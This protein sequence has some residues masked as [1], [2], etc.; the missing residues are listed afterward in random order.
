M[1]FRN[2]T[3]DVLD[4]NG[5]NLRDGRLFLSEN[6]DRP[7]VTVAG[8]EFTHQLRADA[9]DL[10]AQLEAEV[11]R[12]GDLTG[13]ADK[14]RRQGE[15]DPDRV[16]PE[17]LTADAV[18]DAL[19][20]RAFL[21][22]LAERNPGVFR[23]VAEA[24][25]RFLDGLLAKLGRVRDLGSNRYLRDVQAF[26]DVLDDVLAKYAPRHVAKDEPSWI[27]GAGAAE[28]P[29]STPALSE[30]SETTL[31]RNGGEA[32]ASEAPAQTDTPEFRR[33]FGD[34]KVVNADGT[35]RTVYHGTG[36]EFWAFKGDRLGDST[37][38]M[39]APLG[40]FFAEDRAKAERY[41]E[42]AADYVPADQRVIDAH[43][44]IRNPKRM[45]L[46]ELMAVDN[47]DEA[48]AL[49]SKLEREGHDGIHVPEI[50]QWV[51]FEPTQIKSASE[52]RGSFDPENPDIRYSRG[53]PGERDLAGDTRAKLARMQA[54]EARRQVNAGRAAVLSKLAADGYPLGAPGWQQNTGRWEGVRGTLHDARVALQE[55]SSLWLLLADLSQ[56]SCRHG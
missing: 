26:R 6:A 51:A 14:L 33:W 20:D 28:R 30:G 38:H 27:P 54:S 17:E 24:F 15:R 39:T 16:A 50:G 19:S 56:G 40:H 42:K 23:R 13:F 55:T 31:P 5:V 10:Y 9:P 3:P 4:V 11:R 43:L 8:H 18:G 46:D 2:L 44:S 22:R 52:N 45:T 21:Q 36:S 7:L 34:S 32:V 29:R 1:V 48:R 49:R 25:T 53:D 41:A 37:G 35:P 12:Q 47:P